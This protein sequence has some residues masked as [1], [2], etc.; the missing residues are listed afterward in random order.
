MPGQPS[1]KQQVHP[2]TTHGIVSG[3][4]FTLENMKFA[5]AKGKL[6][7][8][9]LPNPESFAPMLARFVF[10][11]KREKG[12]NPLGLTAAY[13]CDAEGGSY[14]ELRTESNDESFAVRKVGE[15]QQVF[16]KPRNFVG[17]CCNFTCWLPLWFEELIF[18]IGEATDVSLK[19][20][21]GQ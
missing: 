21:G 4:E 3:P 5:T 19:I 2:V 20:N 15:Q 11:G 8:Y 9:V 18:G 14:L 6:E 13:T 12:A 7:G 17:K 16:L 10:G 1:K